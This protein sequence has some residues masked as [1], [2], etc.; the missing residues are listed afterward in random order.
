MKYRDIKEMHIQQL[1]PIP[2]PNWV[3][4]MDDK[5]TP[6]DLLDEVQERL[7]D[8]YSP[9]N[10]NIFLNPTNSKIDI[11][12]EILGLTKTIQIICDAD[13][14]LALGS[15]VIDNKVQYSIKHTIHTVIICEILS[16]YLG[17]SSNDRLLLL[18]AAM[19]MNISMKELQDTLYSQNEPLSANQ[20]ALINSHPERSV[21]MLS[22]NGVDNNIWLEIISQHH[23][24]PDGSGYPKGLKMDD[25]SISA[26]IVSLSDI[27]CARVIGRDYRKPIAP[28]EAIKTVFLS[29]RAKTESE[30]AMMF[31][32]IF[33]IYPPGTIVRL[34][35]KE[36]GIV[37][38]RGKKAN[39]PFVFSLLKPDG[40]LSKSPIPRDCSRKEFAVIEVIPFANA[41]LQINR[42]QV[43]GYGIYRRNKPI[44]NNINAQ[45][46][47]ERR[48]ST[49]IPVLIIGIEK[50]IA[51]VQGTI[52]DLTAGGCLLRLHKDLFK[53]EQG[54]YKIMITFKLME[55]IIKNQNCVIKSVRDS[56]EFKLIGIQFVEI[57][58][59]NKE[60]ISGYINY[61]KS[62]Q[63]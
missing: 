7:R 47:N 18:A 46:R 21:E 39:E 29:E 62:N 42:Y 44:L 51:P 22:K 30:L 43:W 6:I 24:S 12:S 53:H 26:R 45:I 50:S 9:K 49:S 16:K 60:I 28:T 56:A 20:K 52:V 11:S 54:S 35:N 57:D 58:E 63:P 15:I 59:K 23:E 3:K 32:K 40:T 31:I 4:Q 61:I 17:W 36:V 19:T 13:P 27:F 33:G 41:K 37:S 55:S 38:Y 2:K 34:T 10:I 14:D 25:I 8:L 48:I 1:K 5:Y